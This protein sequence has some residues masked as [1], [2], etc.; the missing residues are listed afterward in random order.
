MLG[1]EA[2]MMVSRLVGER[3]SMRGVLGWCAMVVHAGW[4]LGLVW[5]RDRRKKL[6]GWLRW[7]GSQPWVEEIGDARIV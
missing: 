6:R 3:G 1:R 5:R 4:V 2:V 7:W